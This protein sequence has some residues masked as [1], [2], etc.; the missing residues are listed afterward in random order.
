MRTEQT[1][2]QTQAINANGPYLPLAR[3]SVAAAQLLQTCRL[4]L[5]QH[6]QQAEDCSQGFS[7]LCSISPEV[8]VL[9]RTPPAFSCA[10]CSGIIT[11]FLVEECGSNLP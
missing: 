10:H 8:L 4:L 3:L 11:D 9:F 6:L 5:T 7:G 2:A 1:F